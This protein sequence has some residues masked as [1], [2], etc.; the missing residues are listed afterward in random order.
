MHLDRA[1]VI[2]HL[3]GSNRPSDISE[4]ETVNHGLT[5]NIV[6]Y[7]M[8]TGRTPGIIFSSSIQA[9]LDNPY[10]ISKRRA[11]KAL[12]NYADSSGADVIIYRLA[13]VFGK[14]CRPNYN[15]VVATFCHNIARDLPIRID[16][17]D[18]E[19]SLVYI[20][21]VVES[22]LLQAGQDKAEN[23]RE[24]K[25]VKPGFRLSLGDLAGKIYEMHQMTRTLRVPDSSDLFTKYLYSTYL[26]YLP[27]NK[28]SYRPPS[29]RDERGSL[30]ELLKSDCMGQVFISS[31]KKG[32]IRGNHY[33]HSKTEKFC[34]IKGEAVIN[35]RKIDDR[36]VIEYSVSGENIEMVNVPPGY[37]HSIENTGEGELI[38]LFW[39]SE[40]FSAEKPDTYPMEVK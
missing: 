29:H 27:E 12:I 6:N 30:T 34:V 2:Y 21:D 40:V 5:E 15:S 32:V 28:F 26:S 10:G 17:P 7:L 24:I 23:S 16:D 33:H 39:A 36:K 4:Y 31:S 3:A 11:E 9:A 37:T 19:I 38:V 14:W 25:R 35:F 18:S 8:Q 13:N 1:D 22:F 20:D